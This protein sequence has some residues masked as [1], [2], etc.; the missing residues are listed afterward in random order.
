MQGIDREYFNSTRWIMRALLSRI[1][2]LLIVAETGVGCGGSG[3]GP[4][5][6]TTLEV[7]P[8]TATLFTVAP[9]NAVT[10]SVVAKDQ[11]GQTMGGVGSPS[12]SSDNGAIASVSVNGTITAVAAGTAR[13]TA[14]LTAGG[15]TKKDTTRVTAL[16]APANA[17]VVAPGVV[18]QPA[19]VDVS[20]G[21]TVTWT[22]ESNGHQ[23]TFTTPGAP[24]D[25]P[26]FQNGSASRTFPNHGTFHYQ[27]SGPQ[28][29]G[30]VIVH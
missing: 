18:F 27:C 26:M 30:V 23:V 1:A 6:F 8:A 28:M 11:D 17:G 12:F 29:A 13:I 22:F 9:G 21:G 4:S 19:T 3:T 14:S 24:A 10:L 5:V 20:A 15:V 16:V 2:T 7:T 25:I